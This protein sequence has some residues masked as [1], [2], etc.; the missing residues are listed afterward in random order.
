MILQTDRRIGW[1]ISQ[2]DD[3]GEVVAAAE[4]I[5]LDAGENG[6]QRKGI[7]EGERACNG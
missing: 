1:G 2:R 4:E 5:E 6:E 3:T 7:D